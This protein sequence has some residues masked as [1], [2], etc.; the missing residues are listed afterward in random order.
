MAPFTDWASVPLVCNKTTV[1]RVL[2]VSPRWIDEQLAAGTMLPAP[3]PRQGGKWQWSKAILQKYID[4]GYQQ[5][6]VT[7]RRRK[8]A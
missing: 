3:M 6:R 7:P 5:M 4:G 8:A 2:N 1:A